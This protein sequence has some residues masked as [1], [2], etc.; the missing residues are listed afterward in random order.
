M[1][2]NKVIKFKRMKNRR[3]FITIANISVLLLLTLFGYFAAKLVWNEI[4]TPFC[5][6]ENVVGRLTLSRHGPLNNTIR[7][8]VFTIF[9]SAM[10]LLFLI[11]PK[12]KKF[13]LSGFT[14][15]LDSINEVPKWCKNIIY[16]TLLAV[17]LI[18]ILSFLQKEFIVE[19][20][21]VFHEGVEL[22]PAFNYLQGKGIWSGTLFVRGAFHD[23][24]T[25]FLGWKI[26]GFNTIGAYRIMVDILRLFVFVGLGFLL[27][28]VWKSIA[29]KYKSLI[30]VQLMLL[31]YLFSTRIQ[32]FDRR[33][34]PLLFGLGFL[35]LAIKNR[36]K[37][38]LFIAGLFSAICTF[39]SLDIGIY[40]TVLLLLV[41]F[42]LQSPI[43]S[44]KQK[45]IKECF[46]LFFGFLVGWLVFYILTGPFE[47]SAFIDNVIYILK[48]KD[49]LDGQIY[50][51][52]DIFKSFRYTVPLL[53]GSF[54]LLILLVFYLTNY[55]KESKNKMGHVHFIL[56][57]L[58]LLHFR[59]ALG[60]ADLMHVEYSSSLLFITM[61]F[62]L[63]LLFFSIKP[64][65]IFYKILI[66]ILAVLNGTALFY[67][68]LRNFNLKNIFTVKPRIESYVKR[69]DY[70]FYNQ[71]RLEGVKRMENIFENER[72]VYDITS[73]ALTPYM[74]K[75]PSCG[76]FY[77]SYFASAES[78]E[79]I[80]L[81]DL[82]ENNPSYILYE[83]KMW[84]QNLDGLTNEKRI[85]LVLEYINL[86]YSHYETISDYW[87]VYKRD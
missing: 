42:L 48:Y 25:A 72:C 69:P 67:P 71:D 65:L 63:A 2:D 4:N 12:F 39:Y 14:S 31:F 34:A 81:S 55:S 87:D 44:F 41:P 11:F 35:I 66:I 78:L 80:L 56:T 27:F 23:L 52:P 3:F 20:F 40:F 21:D 53:I 64:K 59:S 58:S 47:F 62:N 18:P 46:T 84:T 29:D 32:N 70:D 45:I 30:I 37:L 83:T 1:L 82:I 5:N 60:R 50:P 7:W 75:K 85:P 76:N 86:N 22:S 61:G 15:S 77:I 49:L 74:L 51:I 26:F 6:P 43:F 68:F 57:V 17:I 28:A 9:P 10:F 36:N 54:N 79:K 13:L 19:Y 16:L 33:D 73:S 8:A 24:F 38:F